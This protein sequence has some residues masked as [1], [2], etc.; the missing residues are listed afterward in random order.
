[1]RRRW[2]AVVNFFLIFNL[3][4]IAFLLWLVFA[5]M[6]FPA[7]LFLSFAIT[8]FFWTSLACG[9]PI[10][11]LCWF[12]D[13]L[14][15]NAWCLLKDR[16]TRQCPRDMFL[17]SVSLYITC[18]RNVL[19]LFFS[20][21]NSTIGKMLSAVIFPHELSPYPLSVCRGTSECFS[22]CFWISCACCQ[23]VWLCE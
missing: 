13:S 2:K 16:E 11:F 12:A 3:L 7:C 5:D 18:A 15:C 14:G 1:M 21:I 6:P 9:M 17:V 22:S 10:S 23:P 8:P 19:V 4:S 20:L